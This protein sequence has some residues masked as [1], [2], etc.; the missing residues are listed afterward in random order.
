MTTETRLNFVK[1]FLCLKQEL[2][3]PKFKSYFYE[4][5][6]SFDQAPLNDDLLRPT[7]WQYGKMTIRYG[8]SIFGLESA[9]ESSETSA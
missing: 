4:R 3:I 5:R 9:K 7:N 6:R 8:S 2:N 1:L